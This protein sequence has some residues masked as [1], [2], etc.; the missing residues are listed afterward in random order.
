MYKTCIESVVKVVSYKIMKK[1]LFT[2]SP[3]AFGCQPAFKRNTKKLVDP[4]SIYV[5]CV[6][7]FF[8]FLFVK[9]KDVI[10]L[11][12]II[13]T[14]K[15]CVKHPFTCKNIQHVFVILKP[16]I[17]YAILLDKEYLWTLGDPQW[18]NGTS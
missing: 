4:P 12:K 5:F 10:T 16:L 1:L 2:S 17:N 18:L 7:F 6:F 8:I 9:V 14:S 15:G 11:K 13:S 3:P